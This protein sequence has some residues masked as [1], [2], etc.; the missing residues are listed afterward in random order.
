MKGADGVR[1]NLL[2]DQDTPDARVV[3]EEAGTG[4]RVTIRHPIPLWIS[5]P[6]WADRTKLRVRGTDDY[7]LLGDYVSIARPEPGKPVSLEYPAPRTEITLAHRTRDIRAVLEGDAVIAMDNFG[8][9][10]TFFDS[11]D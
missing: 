3:A 10:L 2:L 4:V 5:L 9:D 7:R 11:L 1:V 8:A 6:Q